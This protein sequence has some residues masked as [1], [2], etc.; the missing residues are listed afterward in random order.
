MSRQRSSNILDAT[1]LS[2][3]GELIDFGL[4]PCL[5][6]LSLGMQV[7]RQGQPLG[8]LGD[9]EAQRLFESDSVPHLLEF[10][11]V[12]LSPLLIT[13]LSRELLH[14]PIYPYLMR[15]LATAHPDANQSNGRTGPQVL[16]E[17]PKANVFDFLVRPHILVL[18]LLLAPGVEVSHFELE[19]D[20]KTSKLLPLHA[21][22]EFLG[23]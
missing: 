9:L 21:L 1:H 7:L 6:L 23:K 16:V 12:L 11:L 5:W 17:N 22:G 14:A 2:E 18:L 13:E 20:Y 3:L 15:V 19:A 4:S 8:L 10:N